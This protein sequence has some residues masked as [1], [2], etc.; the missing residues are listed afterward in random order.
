MVSQDEREETG[1]RAILNFGHTVGHAIEAVAGY[2][3]AFQHGEAVAAGMVAE[4]RLAEQREWIAPETTRRLIS[5]LRTFGL[6]TAAHELNADALLEAMTRDKKN[7]DGQI[8][9][10]LPH[11]IGQVELADVDESA[12]R[13]A[14][15]RSQEDA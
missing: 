13:T 12:V 14:L 5:L 11:S 4:C 8:R 7:R 3:G 9:C 6:P 15:S 1:L 2:G 10:V